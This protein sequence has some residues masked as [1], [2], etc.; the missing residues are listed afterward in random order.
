[1]FTLDGTLGYRVT[2]M[3]RFCVNMPAEEKNL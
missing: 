2:R 1:L 3:L